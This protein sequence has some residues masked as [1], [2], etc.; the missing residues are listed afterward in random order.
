MHDSNHWVEVATI[1]EQFKSHDWQ[2][3]E[4]GTFFL[5]LQNLSYDLADI[6]TT[7][8]GIFVYYNSKQGRP[9]MWAVDEDMDTGFQGGRYIP[10]IFWPKQIELYKQ[11][12][13][14]KLLGAK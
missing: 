13:T 11:Y 6:G 1:P 10:E 5:D 12:Q 14:L 3:T 4:R 9:L 2:T 7:V 8:E